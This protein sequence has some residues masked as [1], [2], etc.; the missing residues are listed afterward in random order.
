M[1]PSLKLLVLSLLLACLSLTGCVRRTLLIR[2]A[3]EGALVTV[4]SQT[5]GNAPVSVPF[6]YYGTRQIQLE[7]D[8]YETVKVKQKIRAPWWQFF[9]LDLVTDNFAGRELRDRRVLDF[10]MNPLQPVDQN[11]LLE[12]ASEL[13]NNS[14]SNTVPMPLA[15][16]QEPE[17]IDR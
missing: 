7:K 8:G 15:E 16:R 12:R 14:R 17:T 3:P 9:P 1:A 10:E 11:R 5:I 4:D 2:S 6:T 13:R